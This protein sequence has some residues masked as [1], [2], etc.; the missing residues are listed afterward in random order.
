MSDFLSLKLIRIGLNTRDQNRVFGN[1]VAARLQLK[2]RPRNRR[3]LD[4]AL[5]SAGQ[6][7]GRCSTFG[8]LELCRR[9]KRDP[10]IDKRP[11]RDPATF[12]VSK[13]H[14]RRRDA[15]TST[16]WI[17]A[18]NG[19]SKIGPIKRLRHREIRP[20]PRQCRIL[21]RRAELP[22]KHGSGALFNISG[23]FSYLYDQLGRDLFPGLE[24]G[25]RV[26]CQVI[27]AITYA[28]RMWIK[29]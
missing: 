17:I 27:S 12:A 22:V 23:H 19:A 4:E 24:S 8:F 28:W 21:S 18:E 11:A 26:I 25:S 3:N 10:P 9:D 6:A 5:G 29:R 2:E 13:E 1:C 15:R 20:R 16:F 14:A 7:D